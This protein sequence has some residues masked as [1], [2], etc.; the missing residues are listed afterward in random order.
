[1]LCV[2]QQPS[3]EFQL[4]K[5][6]LLVSLNW[7]FLFR[8]GGLKGVKRCLAVDRNRLAHGDL[9]WKHHYDEQKEYE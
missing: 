1:M 6:T 7:R 5:E 4:L 3:P 9:T 2:S 8:K